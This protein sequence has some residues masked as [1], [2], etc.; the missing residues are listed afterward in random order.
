MCHSRNRLMVLCLLFCLS[1]ISLQAGAVPRTLTDYIKTRCTTH[2]VDP[3]LLLF[4][5]TEAGRQ[6]DLNPRVLL[7]II[8]TESGFRTNATNSRKGKSVGLMQIQVF[9]HRDKFHSKNPYDVLA[10]VSVGAQIYRD[11]V[12][13]WKRSREKALWCYNG[14]QRNKGK[15]YNEKINRSYSQIIQLELS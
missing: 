8:D 14:H 9:W 12:D 4:S 1:M 15:P 2:C 3:D 6:Y 5:V 11:C 7:A 10:N 13:K